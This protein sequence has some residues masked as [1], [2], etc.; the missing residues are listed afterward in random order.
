ML[1]FTLDSNCII[2]LEK[3]NTHALYLRKLVKMHNNQIINLRVPAIVASEKK[4]DD[5]YI[6]HFNEFKQRLATIGLG[7]VEILPTILYFGLSFF[8]YCLFGG[9]KLDELERKIQKI[10]FPAIELNYSDF[11]KKHRRK[12]D[13]EKAWHKWVN[14]KC[15]VLALWSHIWYSGDIFVTRD[16]DFHRKAEKLIKL[17]AGRILRPIEAIRLTF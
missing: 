6:S 16:N 4:P 13:D 10:M 7:N 3:N 15:D 11:C 17:G 8:D 12:P 1:K 5:T 14:A 2:D 9:G